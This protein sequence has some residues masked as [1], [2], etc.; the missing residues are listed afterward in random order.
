MTRQDKRNLRREAPVVAADAMPTSPSRWP[1][2]IAEM[3]DRIFREG[4]RGVPNHDRNIVAR[5]LPTG[6]LTRRDGSSVRPVYRD[7][8]NV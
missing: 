3:A 5:H 2:D 4:E 1:A 6:C 8:A 7:P